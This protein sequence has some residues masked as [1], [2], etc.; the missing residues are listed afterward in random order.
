MPSQLIRLLLEHHAYPVIDSDSADLFLKSCGDAVLF[1]TEDPKRYPE[2]ND[3]A[4][5]LP[6]LM[7]RFE[8]RLTAAVVHRQAEQQLRARF[9]FNEWP[10]LVFVRD[11]MFVGA[12][13]RVQDWDAYL[14]EFERLLEAEP[15]AL[16]SVGIPVVSENAGGCH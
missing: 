3:V 15:V 14:R 6:E 8:G 16:K 11:G 9:P 13:T 10:A 7:Q 4:V 1:F 2:S 12:V 5:I